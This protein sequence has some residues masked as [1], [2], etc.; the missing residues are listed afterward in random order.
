MKHNLTLENCRERNWF[1]YY[2]TVN[3]WYSDEEIISAYGTPEELSETANYYA[4]LCDN[5]VKIAEL[6]FANFEGMGDWAELGVAFIESEDLKDALR[7]AGYEEDDG[8][9]L[10]NAEFCKLDIGPAIYGKHAEEV[11]TP[12][13]KELETIMN[14]NVNESVDEWKKEFKRIEKLYKGKRAIFTHL[15]EY[16]EDEQP[17]LE[18]R[19]DEPCD[20][21]SAEIL[22]GYDDG[23][24]EY[25]YWNIRFDDGEEYTGVPGVALDIEEDESLTEEDKVVDIKILDKEE[26]NKTSFDEMKE[27]ANELAEHL[28]EQHAFYEIWPGEDCI[29]AEISWG[30]WKY[31]HLWFDHIAEKFLNSKG[32]KVTNID[33][34]TTEEDGSDTYSAIHTLYVAKE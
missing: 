27:L 3:D 34:D 29:C 25:C 13:V 6:N 19:E 16:D 15:D 23:G 31:D 26:D 9:G 21:I 14:E 28:E 18:D 10:E 7:K 8:D 24:F 5:G 30:D 12:F 17:G 33:V 32:Y 20:I 4:D 1:E 11:L 2:K 22:D